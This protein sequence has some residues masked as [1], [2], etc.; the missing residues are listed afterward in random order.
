MREK[1]S[2][3]ADSSN[4]DESDNEPLLKYTIPSKDN[5]SSSESSSSSSEEDNKS[6]KGLNKS[7]AN[8]NTE[9]CSV[10]RPRG[11]AKAPSHD[12]SRPTSIK[13]HKVRRDCVD[14]CE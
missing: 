14:E 8:A 10:G 5:D 12:F 7:K 1:S 13:Q 6:R 11:R 9:K 4:W 3:P 2:A